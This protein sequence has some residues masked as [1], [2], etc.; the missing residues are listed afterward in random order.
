[1]SA[2]RGSQLHSTSLGPIQQQQYERK[3]EEERC[4]QVRARSR[5]ERLE[6]QPRYDDDGSD[7]G[8]HPDL[9]AVEDVLQGNTTFD[10][11]HAGEELLNILHDIEDDP[12][13][14]LA[15]KTP[16]HGVTG[17]TDE[18]GNSNMKY[19]TYSPHIWPGVF[20]RTEVVD[21]F[22]SKSRTLVLDLSNG[23]LPALI[24]RGLIPC[25][26]Q[27]PSVVITVQALE[28][29]R[30][31]HARCPQYAIDAFVKSLCDLHLVPFRPYLR[32]QFSIAYDLYLDLR[33]RS[34]K[35]VL[36]TLGRDNAVWRLTQTCPACMYKL[37][38]EEKLIFEMLV[39]MD[40]N[41]SLKRVLRRGRVDEDGV[42]GES[43]ERED[44][45]DGGDGYILSWTVVVGW[46]KRRVGNLLPTEGESNP[47]AGRWHN[48]VEDVT[49]KMWA[50]FNETGIFLCLCRH[51]FVLLIAD[52]IQSGELMKYPLAMTE[53][54]L[55]H[56][57]ELIALGYDIGCSFKTTV[58]QSELGA[59]AQRLCLWC[60]VGSFHSHAH[61]RLCQLR[62][63]ATYV[64][65]MGMEDLEGCERCFSR[66]NG[67]ARWKTGVPKPGNTNQAENQLSE[68]PCAGMDC[69][70][71]LF[72]KKYRS[73]LA[74]LGT[75]R[76]LLESMYR[77]GMEDIEDFEQALR[78]E[79]AFL[80][81]HLQES[82]KSKLVETMEMEY[83]R[84]MEQHHAT[85]DKVKKLELVSRAA[86]APDADF[87]PEAVKLPIQ[88]RHAR[89]KLAQE[90]DVIDELELKLDIIVPWTP[91]SRQWI[92]TV[93]AVR[94][95]AY[96]KALDALELL[97]IQRLLELTKMNRSGTGYKM[98]K[99]I[100]KALQVRSKAIR[101]AL[102]RYNTAATAMLPSKP[103]LSWEQVVNY[104]FL[105]D[106][107]LLRE[108]NG[109]D[110]EKWAQPM[111]RFLMDSFFKIE[112]AREEVQRLNIEICRV[113]TWIRD[114][115]QYLQRMEKGLRDAG[116]VTLAVQMK[117][118]GQQRGIFAATHMQKFWELAKRDGFTGSLEHGVAVE[119]RE[120]TADEVDMEEEVVETAEEAAEN[121]DAEEE[122]EEEEELVS[123]TWYQISKLSLDSAN[124]RDSDDE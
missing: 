6:R 89:G 75:E 48:M 120:K 26:P 38:G 36:D 119:A 45:R 101:A 11:S 78:D 51:G 83:V 90:R 110:G 27:K 1:M 103:T 10:S 81:L 118:Y 91:T 44:N 111:F 43:V 108:E 113:V 65:G 35:L 73:A 85:V 71:A 88:L 94:K 28:F 17:P 47:C 42:I 18:I 114:E 40:G 95:H 33:R 82:S 31:A 16:V 23:L 123:E 52:M 109:V 59:E 25:A 50:V 68:D 63:L 3:A 76:D 58:A 7:A 122:E 29:Y 20:T 61:N 96:R 55:K 2:T 77:H 112:R 13:L 62:H 30:V 5:Q 98:R 99:H 100:A 12:V 60:L 39:T 24:A 69:Q 102:E 104:T 54:L 72:C 53:A 117:C 66:S 124:R 9:E 37:E 97:V 105:S 84:R 116:E 15:V 49:A 115:R 121:H 32:T 87:D 46:A 22:E 107:D 93:A 79:E 56:F 92:E 19:R 80:L 8:Q 21:V 41:D 14:E 64:K 34:E 67:L 57:G 74:V 4:T 106:F 70:S 86:N